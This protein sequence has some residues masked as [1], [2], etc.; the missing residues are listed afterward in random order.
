MTDIT[1]KHYNELTE[2]VKAVSQWCILLRERRKNT[3][4]IYQPGCQLVQSL[5]KARCS[6]VYFKK[7]Q[8]ILLRCRRCNHLHRMNVEP[9]ILKYNE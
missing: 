7:C 9:L 5:P 1:H 6:T 8:F 4:E 2:G 3:H